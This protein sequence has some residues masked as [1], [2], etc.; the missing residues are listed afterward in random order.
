MLLAAAPVAPA[1]A[2]RVRL[3]YR[4]QVGDTLRLVLDQRT[5][6][7]GRRVRG[8]STLASTRTSSRLRVY[9]HLIVQSADTGGADV[10]S[11][12][13]SISLGSDDRH[14]RALSAQLQR[15]LAGQSMRLRLLHDGATR[16]ADGAQ[17]A[18][19]PSNVL[20]LSPRTLPVGPVRVGDRWQGTIPVPPGGPF[21]P[22][23]AGSLRATYRLDS[24]TRGGDAAWISLRGAFAP[25]R[26]SAGEDGRRVT[27]TV[28]GA[29]RLDRRRG[30][31]TD[32]RFTI[33]MHSRLP[34][35]SATGNAMEFEM[36]IVQRLYAM[37]KR[38]GGG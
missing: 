11:V 6:L 14:E 35:D 13:D 17:P 26:G 22:G 15:A 16:L 31:L 34:A 1:G 18:G 5:E 25:G 30:W 33:V 10:L 21:G 4:P 19:E 37:D 38:P 9:S 7:R 28:T 8:D 24:L 20:P 2:Q 23:A 3:E 36:R 27:G 29:L 12:T 32:S